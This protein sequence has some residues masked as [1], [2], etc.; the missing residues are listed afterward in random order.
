MLPP[1]PS[2]ISLA[3]LPTPLRKLSRLSKNYPASIWLKSDD[4]SGFALSGNKVRKLEYLLADAIE[5]GA[6]DI[7]TCGGVQSNHCRATALACSRMGLRCHL[8]LRRDNDQPNDQP[9]ANHFLD[10]L[11]GAKVDIYSKHGF[12]AKLGQRFAEK[13]NEIKRN[14]GVPY[15]IPTGGSNG[16]G[17]WGYLEAIS[18]LKKQCEDLGVRP[19]LIVC[20][21]GSGG[22]QAGLTLGSYIQWDVPVLGF[23]VCDSADYFY[24]K[25]Q[26]DVGS[27]CE[28]SGISPADAQSLLANLSIETNENYI[29]P[30]YAKAAPEVF[31]CIQELAQNEGIILDPIYTG[32]AMYGLLSEL[33]N[34]NLSKYKN[35]IFIHTGGAFGL[36]SQIEQVFSAE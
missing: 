20:A 32:K 11:A 26:S 9:L 27:W 34:G 14:G 3:N 6:T 13:E 31:R 5:K 21:S 22:T 8:I 30:G 25:I 1:I 17:V 35:I 7:I 24:R 16:L 18:E 4:Q 28:I 2:K 36:F 33:E 19:D 23:A 15:S 29:G 10:L 12:P